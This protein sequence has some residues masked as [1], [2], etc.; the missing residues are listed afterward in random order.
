MYA[1]FFLCPTPPVFNGCDKN[2]NL[3]LRLLIG[4]PAPRMIVMTLFHVYLYLC[5]QLEKKSFKN[6][7]MLS[8]FNG[9][10]G[11]FSR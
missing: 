10:D 6:L 9:F 3:L 4:C 11:D 1:I 8:G 5:R 7:F 2:S